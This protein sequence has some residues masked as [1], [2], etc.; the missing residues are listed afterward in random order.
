MTTKSTGDRAFVVQT[1]VSEAEK[2]EIDARAK[3]AGVNVSQF[4]RE[5]M[6]GRPGPEPE[7]AERGVDELEFELLPQSEEHLRRFP[8]DRHTDEQRVEFDRRV[9]EHIRSGLSETVA[10]RV[11]AREMFNPRVG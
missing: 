7:I 8:L 5:A 1:R 6:L 3:A 11:S 10:R 2:A 9:R 4:A